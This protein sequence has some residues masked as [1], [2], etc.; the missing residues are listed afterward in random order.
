[1]RIAPFFHSHSTI[2]PG[3]EGGVTLLE[4]IL[5]LAATVLVGAVGATALRTYLARAEIEESVAFAKYAQDQI[6]RSFRRTGSPPADGASAGFSSDD[7]R[8]TGR[9]VAEIRIVDGRIDLVFGAEASGALEG[10]TLS[11]TP[12]E[13]ADGQVVWVCGSKAPGVGLQPLGF[14]GGGPLAVQPPTTIEPRYLPRTCR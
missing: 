8:D 2:G 4:G 12:F 5:A 11:L 10:R 13:T 7:L 6:T 9:Y 1:M 14:A 3:A